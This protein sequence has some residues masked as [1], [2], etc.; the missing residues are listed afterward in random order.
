M[1]NL[2]FFGNTMEGATL[3]WVPLDNRST[4]IV[5]DNTSNLNENV[6]SKQPFY[7][8]DLAVIKIWVLFMIFILA[9]FGNVCVIFAL[10]RRQRTFSKMHIFIMHLSIAD[11]LVAFLNVLPQ[12]IWVITHT[13]YGGDVLC[14]TVKFCQVFVMYLSTY[15]LVITSVDRY[16]AIC[17]PL[18][19]HTWTN[20]LVNV[21][22]LGIYV[23]SGL[24]SVPQAIMLNI[25]KR[26]R[27]HRLWIVG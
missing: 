26:F 1:E 19:N 22:V 7:Q 24:L 27:D 10:F 16:R 5:S 2:L 6:T 17:H 25:R 8:D 12:L 18:S 21:M 3:F 9:I 14:R 23:I 4:Y 15:I 11:I 20:D 13:W